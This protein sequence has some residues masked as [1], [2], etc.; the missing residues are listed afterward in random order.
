MRNSVQLLELMLVQC[1]QKNISDLHCEPYQQGYRIRMRE[2]GI[3]SDQQFLTASEGQQV[4]ARLKVLSGLNS[5]PRLQDGRFTAHGAD[6]R[7]SMVP[8]YGGEKAV[9]RI[10]RMVA[11]DL[12]E[13]GMNAEIRA[14][15]LPLLH[16]PGLIIVGGAT[17]SGKTTTIHALLQT[18]DRQAL[19]IVTLEDPIEYVLEGVSQIAIS[20]QVCFQEALRSVLRQDPDVLFLG[21]IRDQETAAV[22]VR[23]A[24]TGHT[25]LATIHARDTAEIELRLLD[26]G[27]PAALLKAVIIGR[28]AQY[29]QVFGP[30]RRAV[31]EVR[32]E[33]FFQGFQE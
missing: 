4:L 14:Q 13:L 27:V 20:S 18:L 17:G 16:R 21:E 5:A 3:L 29:L 30:G 28:L 8:V 2:Q 22:A 32:T 11:L 6:F 26:L 25:V 7:V 1:L 9:V 19:H 15:I 33:T 24:L 31:F 12:A 23:A 10:L